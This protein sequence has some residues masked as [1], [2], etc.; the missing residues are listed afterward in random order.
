MRSVLLWKYLVSM[1]M[2]FVF[3]KTVIVFE[4][5]NEVDQVLFG[6]SSKYVC[7]NCW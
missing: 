7:G 3:L 4:S 5:L 2:F 6:C 1:M